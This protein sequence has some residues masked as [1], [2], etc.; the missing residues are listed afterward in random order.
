MSQKIVLKEQEEVYR[1]E[2]RK[3]WT[4]YNK[5]NTLYLCA[6]YDK[7]ETVKPLRARVYQAQLLIANLVGD[8][9]K[10]HFPQST[11]AIFVNELSTLLD[12]QRKLGEKIVAVLDGARDEA[13]GKNLGKL[14]DQK[15]FLEEF[16][17]TKNGILR[18]TSEEKD[19]RVVGKEPATKTKEEDLK[20]LVW[21]WYKTSDEF[22]SALVTNDFIDANTKRKNQRYL[23]EGFFRRL[24]FQLLEM[25]LYRAKLYPEWIDAI[26]FSLNHILEQADIIT[27]LVF[28]SQ[29]KTV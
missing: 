11:T 5:Y 25:Y 14:E 23:R 4:I 24:D 1:L 29:P 26:E 16:L 13:A 28:Q 22:V 7:L 19:L 2:L 12:T 3:I 9:I 21:M 17:V 8:M 18:Y 10:F 15:E 6:L 27:T 20:H